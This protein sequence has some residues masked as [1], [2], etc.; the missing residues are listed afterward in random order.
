M[1]WSELMSCSDDEL[2][3]I[4]LSS[5]K[6]ADGLP[7][8]VEREMYESCAEAAIQILEDRGVIKPIQAVYDNQTGQWRYEQTSWDT[9]A[10]SW[11][12]SP[13]N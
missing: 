4:I 9:E 1:L 6:A 13:N 5:L 8:S 12:Q 3:Y 2:D 7:D 11:S 10:G